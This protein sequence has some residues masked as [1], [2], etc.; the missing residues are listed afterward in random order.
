MHFLYELGVQKDP[1]GKTQLNRPWW[2]LITL[3][4]LNESYSENYNKIT[5]R[6]IPITSD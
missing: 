2:T 1:N 3:R 4:V 5:L 6:A